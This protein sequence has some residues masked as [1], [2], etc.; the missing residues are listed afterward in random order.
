MSLTYA[1][2]VAELANLCVIDAT[3]ADFVSNLPSCIDYSEQRLYR[4]LDLLSTV[5]RDTGLLTVGTRTFTLPQN[6]GR[7]VVVNGINAIT[8]AATTNPDLGTRNQLVPVSRDFLDVAWPSTSGAGVPSQ[9]AMITDQ[10]VIVGPSPDAAYTA[11][12][13]GTIRPTPLSASNPTTYLT[14][15]LPDLFVAASMIFMSGYMRN[16]GAQADDP[17]MAVSWEA[18]YEKLFSSANVEEQRKRFASGA[19]GSLSPNPIATSNR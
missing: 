9:F 12:V 17:R 19:W 15:Y 2:W 4:E 14:L 18:Q 3:D 13:I 1:Q 8:P 16:W 5:T 10:I 11:E 6:N 7:F